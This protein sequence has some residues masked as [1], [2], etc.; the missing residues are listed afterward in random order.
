MVRIHF[1]PAASPLRTSFSGGKRGKIR[2]DDKGESRR[3]VPQAEPMVRIRLPPGESPQTIGSAG[4][5][6]SANSDH[7]EL[8][9]FDRQVPGRRRDRDVRGRRRLFPSSARLS[10]SG[11]IH[12]VSK[13]V[14][15][16]NDNISHIDADTELYAGVSGRTP[17]FR[18]AI[19]RCTS[20]AQC[21]ASTTLLNSTSKIT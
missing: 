17:A 21:N 5:F 16:L 9:R 15:V 3:R 13:D 10:S 2:G 1:P 14:A 6:H 20:T 4:D 11:D 18:P 7:P 8:R 12:A 19:S